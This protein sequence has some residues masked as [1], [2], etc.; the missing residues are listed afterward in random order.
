MTYMINARLD[1][2]APSLT[3]TDAATGQVRLQWRGTGDSARDWRRLFARLVLLSCADRI[4]LIERARSARFGEECLECIDCVGHPATPLLE[5]FEL[6]H[7]QPGYPPAPLLKV[8]SP[9]LLK[10]SP[11][12]H[13]RCRFFIKQVQ[14]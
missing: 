7:R 5:R 13:A 14:E 10:R 12:P 9:P 11:S 6:E 4:Q 8:A 1:G 2:D 3:L